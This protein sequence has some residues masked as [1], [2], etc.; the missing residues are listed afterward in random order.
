[1]Q[2]RRDIRD[3]EP[4]STA[5]SAVWAQLRPW[6]L[7]AV[8]VAGIGLGF[9]TT[10]FIEDAY[11]DACLGRDCPSIDLAVQLLRYSIL[12][13]AFAVPAA[14]MFMRRYSGADDGR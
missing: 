9:W 10:E 3:I 12:M 1:M 8:W 7:A 14:I 2:R 4:L 11:E 6:L 5:P 13:N